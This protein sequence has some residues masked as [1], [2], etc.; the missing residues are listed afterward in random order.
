M[1]AGVGCLLVL[2]V[3]AGLIALKERGN[4][5]DEATI[6]A[7]QRLGAQA[8]VEDDLDH[9][10]LLARQGVALHDSVQTRGNLLAALFRSPA[11]IGVIGGNGDR[12]AALD[13]SPD[14]RTLAVLDNDARL[15]FVDTGT[16]RPLGRPQTIVSAGGDP[17]GSGPDVRFSAD[18]SMLA[19]GGEQ[20]VVLDSQNHRVLARPQ[21]HPNVGQFASRV[22]F[23]PDGR[24]LF[25]ALSAVA[26]GIITIQR[27]DARSGRRLGPEQDVT[28]RA[29]TAALMPTRDGRHVVTSAEGG[30]TVI[31]DARTLTPLKRLPIGAEQAALSP[32]DRTLLVGG[33]DGSVRFLDLITGEVRNASGRHDGAVVRATF[34]SDGNSGITAGADGRVVVWDVE[35]AAAAETLVGHAGQVTG[36]VVSRDGRTLYSAAR[37][38]KVIVWDLTGDRRLGRPFATGA[39]RAETPGALIPALPRA[40]SLDGRDLAIGQS[41]GAVRLIDARTLR[42]RSRF[43]V[44]RNGPI[45]TMAY[46][47]RSRLLV[48][49]GDDGFLALVDPRR[50]EVVQRLPGSGGSLLSVSFSADGGLMATNSPGRFSPGGGGGTLLWELR[51]GRPVRRPRDGSRLFGDAT[52]SPDGRTLAVAQPGI[53][54]DIVDV[55]TL[56]RRTSLPASRAVLQPVRFTRDG[57]YLIAGSF[58]GWAR[59]WSTETWR[60][61]TRPLAGHT[62]AVVGLSTSPDGHTLAT[63][64]A[65]GTIRLFDLRTQQPLGAPLPAL[66]NRPVVPEFSP[67][68]AYLFAIT[69]AGRAYRW[70]VRPSSWERHACA[71]AGRPLTRTEWKDALP[72]RG[73]APACSRSQL[74]ANG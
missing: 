3:I 45:R 6:A 73:Y 59:L 23:S 70:D 54:I 50:G 66:P 24:T 72:G 2:A 74:P 12:L 56:R 55:A 58:D 37:D 22:R 25:A 68:G 28:R 44:V 4:A 47:P 46:V 61:A 60:P 9:A 27:Y 15:T 51:A 29:A 11:A 39:I 48:V 33:R 40:V 5:R 16:G 67:D 1:L 32:D 57:R 17:D 31:R 36:L 26:P 30:P 69:S 49:G 41:D 14:G 43:R 8:L 52:L 20:P 53:G 63:G 19:V 10:L 62:D 18:G 35:R 42:T 34:N 13:L 71:V 7:A 64:S 38:G 21:L 65:D